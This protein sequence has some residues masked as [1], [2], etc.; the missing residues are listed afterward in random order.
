M[1]L[2]SH[3]PEQHQELDSQSLLRARLHIALSSAMDQRFVTACTE[4]RR[5]GREWVDGMRE[6]CMRAAWDTR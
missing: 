3:K 6:H 4:A 2:K 5:A 1:A